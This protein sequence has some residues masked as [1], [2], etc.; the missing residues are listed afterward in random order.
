MSG[1]YFGQ[2]PSQPRKCGVRFARGQSDYS[3]STVS[4]VA[5]THRTQ[6]LMLDELLNL[7]FR[8]LQHTRIGSSPC[9]IGHASRAQALNKKGGFR[10]WHSGGSMSQSAGSCPAQKRP[11]RPSSSSTGPSDSSRRRCKVT[12]GL[13]PVVRKSTVLRKSDS[14]VI[15]EL[16]PRQNLPTPADKPPF[17]HHPHA[18][19]RVACLSR[20]ILAFR[21]RS[22]AICCLAQ[23]PSRTDCLA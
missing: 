18:A 1:T 19:P 8:Y 2:W 17:M 23:V 10:T 20:F 4:V 11:V 3:I 16:L 21:S 13:V 12:C 6:L 9:Q 15:A 5:T 22:T 7:G 14:R